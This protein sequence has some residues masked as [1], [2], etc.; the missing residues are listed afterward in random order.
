MLYPLKSHGEILVVDDD[1]EIC[2]LLGSYLKQLGYEAN[3]AHSGEEVLQQ[4]RVTLDLILLDVNMPQMSGFEVLNYIRSHKKYKH[5]PVIMVTGEADHQSR[6][7]AVRCGANDFIAKPVDL[8]ELQVR[9]HSQLSLKQA[10][11]ELK[12]HKDHLEV[13]VEER[14]AGMLNLVRELQS[15]QEKV[16]FSY[17]DTI[18]TLALAAEFYDKS[19]AQHLHRMSLYSELIARKLGMPEKDIVILTHASALHD[20]G[21][22]VTPH[23]ILTKTSGLT[24]EE[25]QI[26]QRHTLEGYEMLNHSQSE[27]LKVGC[28][29]ALTHHEKWDGS[30]YPHGKMAN[31]IPIWG[32]I[33]TVADV[34]DALTSIRPYKAAFPVSESL[35]IM[36]KQKGTHFDPQLIDVL[37][38][39]EN[40]IN[41]IQTKVT[42]VQRRKKK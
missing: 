32:R 25:W 36:V 12:Y 14:T 23:S 1:P 13:M 42:N 38:S 19:T 7:E 31:E 2:I 34:F 15:Q 11:D 17:L 9:V 21:K 24:E 5:I 40:E 33:C 26:M 30:G 20:I 3:C 16:Q 4:L 35:N 27:Y 18:K 28:Q 22:M 8:T 39:S 41:S 29:I 37:V 10:V 6:L